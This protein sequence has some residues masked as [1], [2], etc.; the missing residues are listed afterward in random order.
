MSLIHVL[1]KELHTFPMSGQLIRT[2]PGLLLSVCEAE[3]V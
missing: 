3:D 1:L 2:R